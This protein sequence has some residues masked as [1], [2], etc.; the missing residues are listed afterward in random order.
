MINSDNKKEPFHASFDIEFSA[1]E[2]EFGEYFYF[3]E[4]KSKQ[5]KIEYLRGL[6]TDSR[7]VYKEDLFIALKGKNFDGHNFVQKAKEKGATAAVV[8][9]RADNINLKKL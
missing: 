2:K 7:V 3:K 9:L 8:E 4:N 1:F 6:S 5:K